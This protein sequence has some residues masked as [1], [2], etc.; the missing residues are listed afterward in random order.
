MMDRQTVIKS[1]GLFDNKFLAID[2]V[3][4]RRQGVRIFQVVGDLDTIDVVNNLV[5]CSGY[6]CRQCDVVGSTYDGANRE[7]KATAVITTM[8]ATPTEIQTVG[9]GQL[10]LVHCGRPVCAKVAD[11]EKK[12]VRA[13]ARRR[14][15]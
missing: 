1:Q 12:V 3:D 8:Y 4:A 15:E 14:Q 2:D 11:F 9:E 5:G 10:R 13:S 6:C 7:A